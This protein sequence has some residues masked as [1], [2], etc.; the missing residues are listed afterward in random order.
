MKKFSKEEKD[1]FLSICNIFNIAGYTANL[2]EQTKLKIDQIQDNLL[3]TYKINK[4]TYKRTFDYLT[5]PSNKN[6]S[7]LQAHFN[8]VYNKTSEKNKKIKG[9]R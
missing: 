3:E 9:V 7:F 4:E 5:E 1:G 8:K 6:L 2:P